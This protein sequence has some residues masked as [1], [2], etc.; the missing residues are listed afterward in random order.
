MART[1][2]FIEDEFHTIKEFGEI[3][4]LNGDKIEVAVDGSDAADHL[5]GGRYDL[6]VLDIMIPHGDELPE[7]VPAMATGLGILKMIRCGDTNQ[8]RDLPVVIL[9]AAAD[10]QLIREIHRH[11][12][13]GVFL[14]KPV[15]IETFLSSVDCAFLSSHQSPDSSAW[16]G[17]DYQ[18]Q[19]VE[20]FSN[21]VLDI[22]SSPRAGA[23]QAGLRS[24][25]EAMDCDLAAILVHEDGLL[26]ASYVHTP[27]LA[28]M[29]RW[30]GCGIKPEGLVGEVLE[31]GSFRSI[32]SDMREADP[33]LG[34]MGVRSALA[35]PFAGFSGKPSVLLVCNR[36][37]FAKYEA[38]F[39]SYDGELC[40]LFAEHLFGVD[41]AV[42]APSEEDFQ[43][44]LTH[45]AREIGIRYDSLWRNNGSKP[46][47][48]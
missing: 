3:L 14:H 2:L 35:V 6:V 23:V 40:R 7:T 21:A 46:A 1:I 48:S 8:S 38:R 44:R 37:P 47:G 22:K 45:A 34:R 13:P 28:A 32:N 11:L 41:G 4:E 24:L 15:A 12:E 19:M 26:R 42:F 16:A 5:R 29:D 18:K 31:I 43:T 30:S 9:T 36:H 27:E 25:A 20:R 17:D 10:S 33:Q 39:L